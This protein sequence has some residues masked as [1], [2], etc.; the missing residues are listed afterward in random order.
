MFRCPAHSYILILLAM[1]SYGVA[2]NVG[3]ML[4]F[5]RLHESE[6]DRIGLILMAIAGYN[7][8]ESITFWQ[9]MEAQSGN[10][11]RPPK[12]LSTHPSSGRW[13]E[14]LNEYMNE[15]MIIYN[16]QMQKIQ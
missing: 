9:R 12:M 8:Q 2:A 6:A 11:K 7:P 1:A 4:P 16:N 5:S 10:A 14:R 15:A 13:G 3:V